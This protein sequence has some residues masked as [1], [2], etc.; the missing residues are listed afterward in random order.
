MSLLRFRFN[1]W[2][3]NFHMPEGVTKKKK[4]K[5]EKKGWRL[6]EEH[7][8]PSQGPGLGIW[9]PCPLTPTGRP[10]RRREGR[11][12]PNLS[13]PQAQIHGVGGHL[14]SLWGRGTGDTGY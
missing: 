5:K 1:L 11:A 3:E 14:L 12:G 2:L 4:K 6:A 13:V 10:S 8:T 7:L 9:N